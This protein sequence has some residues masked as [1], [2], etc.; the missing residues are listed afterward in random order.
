MA[1]R[2]EGMGS[3]TVTCPHCRALL[4]IDGEGGVVV[5]CAVPEPANAKTSLE[6]RLAALAKEKEQAAAKMAEA[7]RAERT[8]SQVR[9]EKFRKLLETAKNE[10]VEKPLRDIDLD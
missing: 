1:T 8:G 3:F 2:G 10:P 7:M 5:S 9:E 4:E 6:E